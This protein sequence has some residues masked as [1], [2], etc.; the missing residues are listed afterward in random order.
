MSIGGDDFQ[1][2][3]VIG[4]TQQ[5]GFQ[6]FILV[7]SCSCD[8]ELIAPDREHVTAAAP[9][10]QLIQPLFHAV[11]DPDTDIDDPKAL[12]NGG[13]HFSYTISGEV[14]EIGGENRPAGEDHLRTGIGLH[15]DIIFFGGMVEGDMFRSRKLGSAVLK[16][17]VMSCILRGIEPDFGLV[18][19]G[20]FRI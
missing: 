5:A 8:I 2:A 20:K 19:N 17:V 4:H 10:L 16:R 3:S 18:R 9:I 13:A 11:I 1:P 6:N 15:G 12:G 14:M 7:I